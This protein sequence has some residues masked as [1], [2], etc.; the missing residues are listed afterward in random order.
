VVVDGS[1]PGQNSAVTEAYLDLEIAGSVAPGATVTL[2]TSGGTA[3]TSGLALAAMRAVEDDLAGAISVSYGECEMELGQ[4]GNAFWSALWEEAAAQGQTVFVSA[5]DGGSAGCDNFD[6]QQVAYDGLQVNGIASTPYNVAVGG[7]DFF[8][9]QYA[10]S[11]SAIATQLEGYWSTTSTLL[12]SVS[13][14]KTIPEQAWNDFFGYNLYD[15]GN[16]VN[17]SSELIVGGGRPP[18]A[19]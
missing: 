17:L 12:P 5:G 13:L 6:T 10:G 15:S 9:N 18:T 16:P 19:W 14:L 11:S 8:Y 1:D 3:L 4:G 7:T 2:Y